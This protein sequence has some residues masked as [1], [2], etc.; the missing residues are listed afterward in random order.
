MRLTRR[1]AFTVAAIIGLIVAALVYYVLRQQ[2]QV[3]EA[4]ETQM[5]TVLVAKQPI[6]Q[7][8]T[9]TMEMLG[10]TQLDSRAAPAGALTAPGQA[11]GKIARRDILAEEP[12][13]MS[14]VTERTAAEGLTFVIPEGMRAVTVA[15][16]PISG[17]GGFV[18]PHDRVD[19]LTTFQQGDV[20]V[21]KMILQNVEVLAMN[22]QTTRPEPG[23]G[24][25]APA[26]TDQSTG[27]APAATEGGAPAQVQ[28]KSATLAVTPDQAQRV[29]LAAFKGAVHLALRPRNEETVVS[30][31]GQTDW[32]LVGL[33]PPAKAEEKKAEEEKAQQ[34]TPPPGWVMYPPAGGSAP[35][36][37]APAPRQAPAPAPA[38]APTVEVIRG[39]EREVV[40]L[41]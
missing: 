11:V 25:Q 37:A 4:P 2:T 3:T 36:A 31:P 35:A 8:D 32:A 15:L 21:T 18:I 12:L 23:G 20:A 22:E 38:P 34:Q 30:L 5:V 41:D 33:E 39:G 14:D 27:A 1:Q 6:G 10:T 40:T 9:I 24:T 17:V 16:D 29:L 7:S 28:V 13:T 26:T 19:V